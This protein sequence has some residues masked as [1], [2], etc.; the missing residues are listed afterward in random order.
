MIAIITPWSQHSAFAYRCRKNWK[1][2]SVLLLLIPSQH[3]RCT[4]QMRKTQVET[5]NS[6]IINTP[7]EPKQP[8]SG[9]RS[10]SYP[11]WVTPAKWLFAPLDSMVLSHNHIRE[12]STGGGA[13]NIEQAGWANKGRMFLATCGPAGDQMTIRW[14]EVLRDPAWKAK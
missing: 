13:A 9:A 4:D 5:W 1:H 12:P 14:R 6:V 10:W 3:A 7:T 2:G 11:G 8:V